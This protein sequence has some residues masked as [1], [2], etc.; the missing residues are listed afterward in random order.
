M[1]THRKRKSTSISLPFSVSLAWPHRTSQG[2]DIM[3]EREDQSVTPGRPQRQQAPSIMYMG[4]FPALIKKKSFSY[5][6]WKLSAA[7]LGFQI[8]WDQIK[9]ISK[10]HTGG[11][12]SP[13]SGSAPLGE[14]FSCHRITDWNQEPPGFTAGH[15]HSDLKTWFT[16]RKKGFGNHRILPVE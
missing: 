11:H 4:K 13:G 9:Y 1:T 16:C 5:L 7:G 10:N 8:R 14:A 3:E 2:H 6:S 15:M 12:Q